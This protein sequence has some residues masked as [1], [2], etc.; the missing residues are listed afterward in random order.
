MSFE[1]GR[2]GVNLFAVG[3]SARKDLVL[4]FDGRCHL[5]RRATLGRSVVRL[6]L[7]IEITWLD[8]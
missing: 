6:Y 1:V 3:I 8:E 4:F 2:F 7:V 5:G